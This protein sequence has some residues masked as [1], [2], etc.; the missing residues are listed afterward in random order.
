MRYRAA[1]W[2]DNRHT[3]EYLNEASKNAKGKISETSK[4][5]VFCN[6]LTELC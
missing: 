4:T 6:R 5:S 2:F 1:T 3:G